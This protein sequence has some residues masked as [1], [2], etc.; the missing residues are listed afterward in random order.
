MARVSKFALVIASIGATLLVSP[1]ATA[2]PNA[3]GNTRTI[4][5]ISRATAIN[6]FID[7]QPSGPSPGDAYVFVDQ[8]FD[9]DQ[10][11]RQ[12]G[13]ADG[14]CTMIDPAEQRFGCTI[15]SSFSEGTIVTHGLLR[16][17]PGTRSTG[18][19]VG[20]TGAYGLARGEATLD[21]GPFEGPHTATF[22]LVLRP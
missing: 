1:A 5:A 17:V 11:T 2:Q 15:V 4:T 3:A 14:Q 13:T 8:F 9:P 16:L 18:A 7:A 10:P 21:L 6:N 22:N 20:G 19:I 12:I